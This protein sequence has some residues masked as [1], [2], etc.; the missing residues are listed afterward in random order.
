MP[1]LAY[2]IRID[3]VRVLGLEP[4]SDGIGLMEFWTPYAGP[5]SHTL[6]VR[7]RTGYELAVGG[8]GV[9]PIN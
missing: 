1:N 8:C 3:G 4:E 7:P 2:E 5:G 9:V 6:E